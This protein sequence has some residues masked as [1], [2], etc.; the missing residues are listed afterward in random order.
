MKIM[1]LRFLCLSLIACFAVLAFAKPSTWNVDPAHSSAGFSVRHMG[2][3]NVKGHFSKVTGT[4]VL[5][6]Q[7]ITRSSVDISIDATTVDTGV[8][9]RDGDLKGANYFDVAK[10]PTIT[11]KSKGV[12]KNGDKLKVNGDLTL[13]GVTKPATLD[14]DGPS[15]AI[16]DPRGNSHRGFSAST[17]LNRHDFGVDGGKM[18]VGEIV[19]IDIDVEVVM[20][21]A[22]TAK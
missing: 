20:P 5:D 13:H 17:R 18:A 4:V 3:S 1:K 19:Q 8:S 11:F 16:T 15:D 22:K 9:M 21:A 14:V 6:D 10:Y 7:D 2:I 12:E